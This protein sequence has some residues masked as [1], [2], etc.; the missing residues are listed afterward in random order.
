M[1][2]AE[3]VAQL[4]RLMDERAAAP[5]STVW[6]I[7]QPGAPDLA[8]ITV[9]STHQDALDWAKLQPHPEDYA[10]TEW[11]VIGKGWPGVIVSPT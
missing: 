3:E 2:A 10:Y 6:V 7:W 1:T 5:G 11:R 4:E 8:P 9:A